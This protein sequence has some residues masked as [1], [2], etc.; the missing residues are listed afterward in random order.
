MR[1]ILKL[2]ILDWKRIFKSKMT[3]VII[4]GLM[5]IPSMYAWFNIMA[6]W[7]PYGSTSELPIAV[8]SIDKG[9][10]L[11]SENLNFGSE[12][13]TNLKT[14]T[15]IGWTFSEDEKELVDGV[16]SGKY[17]A[18]IIIDEN[19]SNDLISFVKGKPIHPQIKYLVNQKI[20]AIAPKISDAGVDGIKAEVTNNL[21]AEITK[22]LLDNS[23]LLGED[24]AANK[25][26]INDYITL[27]NNTAAD[28]DK[29][30]EAVDEIHNQ[31]LKIN[32]Y[33]EKLTILD[34][35]QTYQPQID[36]MVSDVKKLNDNIDTIDQ[37]LA[38]IS[39]LSDSEEQVTEV[40]TK[41]NTTHES[42]ITINEEITKEI[43]KIEQILTEFNEKQDVIDSTKSKQE[44]TELQGKLTTVQTDLTTFNEKLNLGKEVSYTE[45]K[46]IKAFYENDWPS[47]KVKIET[48]NNFFVNDWPDLNQEIETTIE[49]IKTKSEEIF[50]KLI[51]TDDKIQEI[52]P[53]YKSAINELNQNVNAANEQVDLEQVI[54]L[55]M[56]NPN[57]ESSFFADP[58]KIVEEDAYPVPNY[59]SQSTPFYTALCLW[60]G[61]LLLVSVLK[62]SYYLPGGKEYSKRKTFLARLLTFNTIAIFQGLIVGLGNIYLLNVYVK[63]PLINL[64]SI[65]FIAIIF[66]TIIYTIT[67]LL[68]NFG[69]V[70]GIILLV[71]SVSA[72]GGNF[73]IQLSSQF[74]QTINPLLPFT[75][76]VD[77]L[78]ESTG[79]IYLPRVQETVAILSMMGIFTTIGGTII[80]PYVTDFITELMK[81]SESG[82][83]IH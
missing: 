13:I 72:G 17:Y 82:H 33:R 64:I 15:D 23:N 60:V 16:N 34:N 26:T 32:D 22:T 28:M 30:Q 21:M 74:F 6:L 76:A 41:I 35:Y 11:E 36:A 18:G 80:Y 4:I 39:K 37:K 3:L 19:F 27:L 70:I 81:K 43:E 24:L 49:T 51:A 40:L 10:E 68:D 67:A 46:T 9:T 53:T 5:I 47:I 52:W 57:S 50:D 29:G 55:L 61:G 73:P 63:N 58:I 71:L 12:I 69:K 75:Y 2:F 66:T 20:N 25:S 62:T 45:I 65:V 59:G 42:I 1:D 83:I 56:Y 31:R 44:L 38:A 78:R 54:E 79:G 77:L 7:D 48:L 8:V 14:N